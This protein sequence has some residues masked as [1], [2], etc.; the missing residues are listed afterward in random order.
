MLARDALSV[1]TAMEE[2]DVRC[3]LDG[4]WG[5][6]ALIG[7]QTRQHTDLDLV[8][9]S[10]DLAAAQSVLAAQGFAVLRDWLPT[11]VAM[12]DG[13]GR[14]VDFHPVDATADGG[15]DQLLPDG[16]RYHYSAPGVGMVDGRP[17]PC[18]PVEGQVE[19][20]LGYEP[21]DTDH[22]DMRALAAALDVELPPP[23][24]RNGG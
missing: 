18:A 8:V 9:V 10:T 21:R 11:S 5:V 12:G 16:S 13:E 15:G 20:H 1:L 3:W 22:A 19:M 2:A 4:G 17:V 23:Y 14:E 6:D 7:R 24:S